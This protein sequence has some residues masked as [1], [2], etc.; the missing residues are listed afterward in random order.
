MQTIH[1]AH[2]QAPCNQS[3]WSGQPPSLPLFLHL[4]TVPKPNSI[5][6]FPSTLTLLFLSSCCHLHSI[7]V[8]T[9]LF[10]FTLFST[11][12]NPSCSPSDLKPSQGFATLINRHPPLHFHLF[13]CQPNLRSQEWTAACPQCHLVYLYLRCSHWISVSKNTRQINGS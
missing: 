5:P 3:Q 13:S 7:S 9:L 2:A 12:V 1:T 6:P 11:S 4:N 10:K 8:E